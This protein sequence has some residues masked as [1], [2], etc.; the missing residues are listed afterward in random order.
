MSDTVI[1]NNLE[2][3]KSS[4]IDGFKLEETDNGLFKLSFKND[5]VTCFKKLPSIRRLAEIM[6]YCK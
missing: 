1:D 3:L 4:L 6:N 2:V 5:Q